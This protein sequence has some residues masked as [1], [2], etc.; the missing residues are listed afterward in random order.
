MWQKHQEK[1][2]PKHKQITLYSLVGSL[3]CYLINAKRRFVR[4]KGKIRKHPKCK[5]IQN[6]Q[7]KVTREQ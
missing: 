2:G 4:Y 5:P 7:Q 6:S 3:K 1:V